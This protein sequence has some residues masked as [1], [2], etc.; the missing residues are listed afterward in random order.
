MHMALLLPIPEK[1]RSSTNRNLLEKNRSRKMMTSIK[2]S[3]C[4][5]MEAQ[6]PLVSLTQ[7]AHFCSYVVPD[8]TA[9]ASCAAFPL[10]SMVTLT[11]VQLIKQQC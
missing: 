1:A 5:S 2:V 7:P 3:G 9:E 6:A 11:V 4:D 10:W 8:R